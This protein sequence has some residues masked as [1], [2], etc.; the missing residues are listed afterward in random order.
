[1]EN[2]RVHSVETEKGLEHYIEDFIS[3]VESN[4]FV[5]NNRET[6]DMKKNFTRHGGQV[7][8]D[9]DLHMIQV[10]KPTKADKSLGLNPERAVLMPKFIHVFSKNGKTQA[11]FLAHGADFI[12][13][14]VP[15][16]AAFPSSLA[17]TYAKIVEMMEGAAGERINH[18]E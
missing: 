12:L 11:R 3:L 13:A 2:T 9:F 18:K 4:G 10:C 15:G 5:V 16:D 7:A 6:M 1:M 14:Q 17:Q 8:D